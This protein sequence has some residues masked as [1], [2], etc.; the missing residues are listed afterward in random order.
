MLKRGD[1]D[2]IKTVGNKKIVRVSINPQAIENDPAFYRNVFGS[3][4]DAAKKMP[5]P[6]AYF[7]IIKDETFANADMLQFY[8]ENPNVKQVP[9]KPGDEGE[10]FGQII[11]TLLTDII[12]RVV[13]YNDDA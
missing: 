9:D 5:E 7:P 8:K 6:Q 10:L 12:N 13:I 4:Y 3:D 1:V 11:S 2:Q